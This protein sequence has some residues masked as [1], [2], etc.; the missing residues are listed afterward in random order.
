MESFFARVRL[1][2]RLAAGF[3][4]VMLVMSIAASIGIWRLAGLGDIADDLGGASAERAVLASRLHGMVVVS[5]FRA[6]TL[7]LIDD[8]EFASRI[9]ADRKITTKESEAV[10]KR[11]D[12]LT[13]NEET[14]RL[15]AAIQDTGD[16]FRSTRDALIKR[17]ETGEKVS[18]ADIA[19]TLRP[20]SDAYVAAVLALA[21]YQRKRVDEA[22]VAAADSARHGIALLVAGI[23]V[24]VLASAAL[25]WLLSRSIVRP[26]A[27]AGELA[28]RVAAGDL[29]VQVEAEGRDEVEQLVGELATM[30]R[31]LA[32]SVRSVQQASESIRTASSEIATGNQDLSARTEQ[33]ASNLQETAASMEQLTGTVRQS[34]ESAR[35]AK[36]MAGS[37]AEAAGRGGEVVSRVVERMDEINLSSKKIADIVGVI[38]GIAFQTNILAL[39]AAVEAARAGEQGRGFAVVASEVRNLAQRSALSAREIKT[40]IGSSV[41]T[42]ESG[43]QLAQEA[44]RAMSEIVTSVQRVTDIIGEISAA[45]VEQ[46]D[47]IGQ[48]NQA[49]TQLDG[50]TQQNS[51]LVEQSSA[52]AESLREQ[53]QRLAQ[54]VGAFRLREAA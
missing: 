37:A 46:S 27:R 9:N 24:G 26:L 22:R 49:V 51:A 16:R 50:M 40:L 48:V 41:E 23:A 6:E 13:D 34:A 35:T 39:N 4:V 47:G 21:D 54:V 20:T 32:E 52:A 17:R 36:Q 25:A 43:S 11:L 15:F 12:E 28:R 7:L 5:A 14:K 19:G 33:A 29:T 38:D 31:R 53:A 2:P 18:N 42:I 3:A 8:A 10:R 44:G 30:Q 1:A 45:A